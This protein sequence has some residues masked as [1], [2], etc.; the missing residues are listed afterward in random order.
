MVVLVVVLVGYRGVMLIGAH[1]PAGDPLKEAALRD[2]DVIQMFVSSP[3]SWKAP[4]ERDDAAALRDSPI[5]I[6]VHAPFILNMVSPNNRVRIPSRKSLQVTCDAAAAIGAKGVVVHGGHL[7]DPDEDMSVGFTRWKKALDALDSE[8]PVLIEN[9]AGGDRAM[10]R[11]VEVIAQ[12]WDEIGETGVGFCLDT[13]HAWAGGEP[14]TEVVERITAITGVIDLVHCN[15]SK[16]EFDARR[17][18]HQNLGEGNIP[19]EEILEVL[20]KANAPVVLETPSGLEG[21]LADL[22]WLR[23][24]L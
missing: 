3:Q 19:G 4:K 1:V 24:R 2:A 10:A 12:L 9:T 21:H 15:D 8:V 23:S 20:R 17:D 18:R 22:A 11:R 13:C 6:Y 5:P 7:T 14:L 16:D